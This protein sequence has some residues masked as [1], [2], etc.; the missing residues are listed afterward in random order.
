MRSSFLVLSFLLLESFSHAGT[1]RKEFKLPHG[2][3]MDLVQETSTLTLQSEETVQVVESGPLIYSTALIGTFQP[4][5]LAIES[6]GHRTEY[7][8]N[9]PLPTI[10]GEIAWY[11][12]QFAGR[13]GLSGSFGYSQYQRRT[14][15]A[16]TVLHFLMT[17]IQLGYRGEWKSTQQFIPHV[18]IGPSDWIYLQRGTDEYNTSE[19]RWLT[20]LSAGLGINLNRLGLL[21]SRIETEIKLQYQRHFSQQ[22][23]NADI[24]S[25]S[26]QLGATLT[27]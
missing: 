17:S 27:L 18:M 15:S 5:Y 19:S 20:T 1:T 14:E 2:P 11:P 8:F 3:S 22:S 12:L 6:H 23:V 16:P 24:N 10:S 9:S 7:N 25:D 26:Y 13:W 4:R 21:E